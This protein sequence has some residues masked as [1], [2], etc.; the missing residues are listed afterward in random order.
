MTLRREAW[1]VGV[2]TQRPF[3]DSASI[4]VRRIFTSI[5]L[6]HEK[7]LL[8]RNL[9]PL[10]LTVSTDQHFNYFGDGAVLT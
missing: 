4:S 1:S 2:D 8:L 3:T 6:L 10:G 9:D 5:V 7:N